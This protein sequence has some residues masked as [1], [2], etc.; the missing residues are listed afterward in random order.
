MTGQHLGSVQCAG[1]CSNEEEAEHVECHV[2]RVGPYPELRIIV[3]VRLL[4]CIPIIWSRRIG[5]RGDRDALVIAGAAADG[6]LRHDPAL[7]SLV[8]LHDGIAIVSG[9][10]VVATHVLKQRIAGG[11]AIDDRTGRL[12]EYR[13]RLVHPLHILSVAHRAIGVG[14]R[15]V[16]GEG[17][18][19]PR[20]TNT[21]TEKILVRRGRR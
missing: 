16:R 9:L 15:R 18:L 5:S 13:E 17:S 8:V 1:P 2:V 11:G 3:E 4:C 12:V 10:A 19:R 14:R 21:N 6:E 7:S 20:K